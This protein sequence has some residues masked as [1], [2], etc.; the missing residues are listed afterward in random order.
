MR[1]EDVDGTAIVVFRSMAPMLRLGGHSQVSDEAAVP[2]ATFFGRLRGVMTVSPAAEQ[3]VIAADP[4]SRYAA[5]ICDGATRFEKAP[6]LQEMRADDVAHVPDRAGADAARAARGV[7]GGAGARDHRPAGAERGASGAAPVDRPHPGPVGFGTFR[8]CAA[9]GPGSE[10]GEGPLDGP[11][12]P[13]ETNACGGRSLILAISTAVVVSGCSGGSARARC[14]RRRGSLR[15][16]RGDRGPGISRVRARTTGSTGPS[17]PAAASS[18]GSRRSA[19]YA[20]DAVGP[21]ATTY[22]GRPMRGD[23]R[24]PGPVPAVRPAHHQPRDSHARAHQEVEAQAQED[25]E[26]QRTPAPVAAA[27]RAPSPVVARPARTVSGDLVGSRPH[28]TDAALTSG[29]SG[30]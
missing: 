17:A 22:P 25:R 9:R 6:I 2:L 18:S 29:P 20:A 24:R 19:A 11:P 8:G 12:R 23:E 15:V 26:A 28:P 7:V 27:S 21:S 5:F 3:R 30:P 13:P 10:H 4:M 14:S 1:A 16:V